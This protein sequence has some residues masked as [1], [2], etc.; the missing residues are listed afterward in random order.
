MEGQDQL[1]T[2]D[3]NIPS[4]PTLLP[5]GA[6]IISPRPLGEGPGV[7][8]P[9]SPASGRGAGGEGFP[10]PAGRGAGG[11]ALSAALSLPKCLSKGEGGFRRAQPS[12]FRYAPLR[13]A[14][15]PAPLFAGRVGRQPV[16][17][18]PIRCR[19]RYAVLLK[20]WAA[21]T[22]LLFCE[23]RSL[24]PEEDKQEGKE[25]RDHQLSNANASRAHT[26]RRF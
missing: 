7:R 16:S 12:R 25:G 20:R 2:N 8:A 17:R 4:S 9:P 6:G 26:D 14:T 22:G 21:C 11:V 3:D 23:I 1:R 18:P 5:K 19:F 24:P 10:S 15:Q 13:S